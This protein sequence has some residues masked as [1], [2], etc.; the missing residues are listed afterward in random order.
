MRNVIAFDAAL[1]GGGADI[2]S[3]KHVG[4]QRVPAVA[5]RP[6]DRIAAA[7][8]HH[9]GGIVVIQQNAAV[10]DGPG[11][12][13]GDFHPDRIFTVHRNGRRTGIQRGQR[14]IAPAR[15]AVRAGIQPVSEY[16]R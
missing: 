10:V 15:L 8:H 9:G 2:H 7:I 5:N 1:T 14:I 12:A 4:F 3:G 11:C 6:V 13:A 16:A